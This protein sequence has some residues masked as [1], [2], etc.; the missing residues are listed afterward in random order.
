MARFKPASE[1]TAAP[2]AAP[3]VQKKNFPFENIYACAEGQFIYVNMDSAKGL[4]GG[5][6]TLRDIAII[7][8]ISGSMASHYSNGSMALM[9]KKL[10]DAL[11]SF[12]DDGIDLYFFAN[13]LV[14]NT[15][16]ANANDVDNAIKAALASRG[17]YGSTMPT[18]AFKVF[19][20][21]LK[22]KG[23]AGTVLF[24]TDGAMDDRG[25]ELKNF[26][27]NVL[28]T[29]FVDRDHFYCYAVEFG[30]MAFGALEVL[31]GL[32]APEQGPEDLFDLDSVE[33]I[34]HIA[35]VLRQVGG[36]SAVGSDVELT[37]SV[38]GAAKIDMV[39]A[40]LIPDG[41]MTTIQ[42][43]INKTMSFRVVATEP[44]NL[45]IKI[46]GYDEMNIGVTPSG[47]EPKLEIR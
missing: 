35:E 6:K 36:M 41:G 37:A 10:V 14:Y 15:N 39:N 8:D 46:Q 22:Q 43:A 34:D 33:K 2:V 40:D 18:E 25:T 38:D 13:G 23:R 31:D 47:Y 17:A 44:F 5:M 27:Q 26:Y 24:L 12:D 30:R 9:C 28:H 42:G 32:Y 19:C 3:E 16:V 21:Q 11:A 1:V 4:Q 29:Q 7:I 20:D 45:K